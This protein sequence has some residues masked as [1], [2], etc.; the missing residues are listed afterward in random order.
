MSSKNE[1]LTV[2]TN[3]LKKLLQLTVRPR[4]LA[5]SEAAVDQFVGRLQEVGTEAIGKKAA[6]DLQ[7]VVVVI[8]G[9]DLSRGGFNNVALLRKMLAALNSQREQEALLDRILVIN[10]EKDL[11]TAFAFLKCMPGTETLV[12]KIKFIE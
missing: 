4:F 12:S 11:K 3:S 6:G 5:D 1:A 7:T 8:D 9:E 2:S 10:A